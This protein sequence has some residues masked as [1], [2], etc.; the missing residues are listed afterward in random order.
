MKRKKINTIFTGTGTIPENKIRPYIKIQLTFT[1][2][3]VSS[4]WF[5]YCG[6]IL[7][8]EMGEITIQK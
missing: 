8:N 3:Y 2:E 1:T 7:R 4:Y 5:Y 6:L